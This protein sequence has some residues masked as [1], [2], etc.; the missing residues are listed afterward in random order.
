MIYDRGEFSR[1]SQLD[2]SAAILVWLLLIQYRSI[3][4]KSYYV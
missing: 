4:E 2:D 3:L 1:R